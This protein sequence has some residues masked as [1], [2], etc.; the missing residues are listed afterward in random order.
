MGANDD[1]DC[2]PPPSFRAC[3]LKQAA[4]TNDPDKQLGGRSVETGGLAVKKGAQL[5]RA[6]L[7]AEHAR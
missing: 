7:I 3:A 6:L 1:E 5:F 2:H 4:Q